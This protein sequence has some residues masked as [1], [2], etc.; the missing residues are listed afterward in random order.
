LFEVLNLFSIF[1]GVVI[2]KRP[3]INE[4]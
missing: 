1:C 3:H 2:V 4:L